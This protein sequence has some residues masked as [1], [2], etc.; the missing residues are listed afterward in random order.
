MNKD[1]AFARALLIQSIGMSILW[2]AIA[3]L[4]VMVIGK[5]MGS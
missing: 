1:K 4:T 2:P 3:A 5:M